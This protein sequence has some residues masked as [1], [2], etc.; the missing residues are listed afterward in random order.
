MK[1]LFIIFAIFATVEVAAA[2]NVCITFKDGTTVCKTETE[3]SELKRKQ[4]EARKRYEDYWR[5]VTHQIKEK[6]K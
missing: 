2:Q 6:S 3:W 5:S 4:T 1:A